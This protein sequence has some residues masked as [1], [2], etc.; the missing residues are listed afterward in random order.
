M[1]KKTAKVWFL[2]KL[3]LLIKMPTVANQKTK[4]L[5]FKPLNTNPLSMVL[6]FSLGF[7]FS[8][9]SDFTAGFLIIV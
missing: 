1:L 7:S 3:V 4:T 5:G 2:L 6:S 9:F 8:G